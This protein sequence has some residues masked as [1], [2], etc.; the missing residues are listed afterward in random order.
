MEVRRKL[1]MKILSFTLASILVFSS[2]IISCYAQGFGV[3]DSMETSEILSEYAEDIVNTDCVKSVD[4]E[5][6]QQMNSF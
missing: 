3:F 4:K 6:V 1:W 5:K 2:G